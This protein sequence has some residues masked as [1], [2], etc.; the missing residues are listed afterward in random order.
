MKIKVVIR[1]LE[2]D[3]WYLSRIKGS[4]GQFKHSTKLGLVAVAGKLSSEIAT[5]TKMSFLNKR[6]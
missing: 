3:G 6:D 4:H 5:G 2:N 1:I